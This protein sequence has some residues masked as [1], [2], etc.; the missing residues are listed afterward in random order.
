M[1]VS[2]LTISLDNGRSVDAVQHL[3]E[4][5]TLP[6]WVVVYAPGAGSS[7][8]D[9]F[10]VFLC[11]RLAAQGIAAVRFQ[12]P[13]QQARSR[14]PDPP[15]LL[16]ATWRAAIDAARPRGRRI[17]VGGRSMGGRIASMV[18]A[19]GT[20][21]DALALFA[22]PLR[23]PGQPEKIRVAHLPQITAPTLFCSGTRDSFGTPGEL[24][25]AAALVPNASLHLL[26][27]ADHGFTCLKSSGRTKQQAWDEAVDTFIAWLHER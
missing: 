9:G 15:A 1:P 22:Y 25:E 19:A 23:P 3:P 16:Q 11:E 14:R 21:V 27:G 5:D 24:A 20:P 8:D 12:F 10:G 18:A 2:P 4:G 13:Y 6:E 17:A 7:L 26:E